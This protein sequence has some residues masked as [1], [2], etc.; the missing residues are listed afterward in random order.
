M[1]LTVAQGFSR[2]NQNAQE[3]AP[4]VPLMDVPALLSVGNTAADAPARRF[5][6]LQ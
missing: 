6:C 1:T 4:T 5:P 2:V 3:S